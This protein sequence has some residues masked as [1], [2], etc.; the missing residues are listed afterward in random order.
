MKKQ[1]GSSR[2]TAVEQPDEL[3]LNS[4]LQPNC[5]HGHLESE[6]S[7]LKLKFQKYE[8]ILGEKQKELNKMEL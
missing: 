6:H 4:K 5:Q 2:Y 1:Q 3:K 8:R 7:E